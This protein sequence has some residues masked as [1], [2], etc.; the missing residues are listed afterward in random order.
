[1]ETISL[2]E[3]TANKRKVYQKLQ[4]EKHGD[5]VIIGGGYAGLSTAYHLQQQNCQAIILEQGKIGGGA[6]GRNGGQILIG[7]KDSI[8]SIAKK[9]GMEQAK[10]MLQLSLDSI[11]LTAEL[12]EKHNLDCAFTR[13]GHV[14]AAYKESHVEYFKQ[15]QEIM[16]QDF[17]YEFDV[18]DR[19]GLRD[20][21]KTE[22]Y[23]GGAVDQN[24]CSFHPLNYA[25]GLAGIVE[26]RGGAIY[27][28]S[29]ALRI[30]RENNKVIV[31]TE[32]GKVVADEIVVVTNGYTTEIHPKIYQSV[33]PVESIMI[34]T[35]SLDKELVE[36]L[37]PNNR[38][39][40]DSKHLLY[41]F[42]RTPD[43]R[44]AFGGSGRAT[45]KSD[46]KRLFDDLQAG[47][48]NVFPEIKNIPVEYRWSGKVGFTRQML[49][50]IGQL[51][52][53][54]YSAFGCAGHGAAMTTL[55]GKLIAFNI[56]DKQREKTAL[57]KIPLKRIP[58]RDQHAK[59]VN[60]MKYYYKY[61]DSRAN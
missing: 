59:V 19:E 45:T 28:D 61:L 31:T 6:S 57:E 39:A 12:I 58:F 21:L 55:L 16:K 34:A 15:E 27:E 5:V 42:R 38:V 30:H 3:A 44:I 4:G 2:W 40:Y 22:F 9:W 1:M 24:S 41:Y 17:N 54:T 33:I 60:L 25:L 8:P 18:I 37:I 43:H 48:I 51:E 29:E 50:F 11:A 26:E 56:L 20:E 7:Y 53:G 23:H 10:E 49:P 14:V 52:D 46:A 47:M 36:S 35:E 32:E 13:S